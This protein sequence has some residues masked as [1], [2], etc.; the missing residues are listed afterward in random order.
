MDFH[1]K[2]TSVK[3][4]VFEHDIAVDNEKA[5]LVLV[6]F[7]VELYLGGVGLSGI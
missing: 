7:N 4:Q 2:F 6:S 5:D 3:H 1:A